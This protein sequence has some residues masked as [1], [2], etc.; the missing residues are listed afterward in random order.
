MEHLCKRDEPFAEEFHIC[1]SDDA[2]VLWVGDPEYQYP[3]RFCPLCGFKGQWYYG[4]F[5]SPVGRGDWS[6]TEQNI[7]NPPMDKLCSP[8]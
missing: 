5:R 4:P 7:F 1:V 2:G 8:R 6:G 3:V